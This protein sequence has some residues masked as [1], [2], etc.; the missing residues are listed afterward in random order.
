MKIGIYFH[1]NDEYPSGVEHY[2]L[3]MIR[4]LSLHVPEN[5]Y[6]VFTSRPGMIEKYVGKCDHVLVRRSND[7]NTRIARIL[8]EHTRLPTLAYREGLDVLHCPAYICP[9]RGG[10]TPYVVTVHD[11]IALDHPEWCKPS[12]AAYFGL[13]MKRAARQASAVVATS[14]RTKSDLERHLGADGPPVRVIYP[15]IDPIFH[16]RMSQTDLHN[17]RARYGLPE[18][19]CLY[20]GNLEPKKNIDVLLR[21]YEIAREK[22]AAC[23][24]V[25]VGKR[26][27]RLG[28]AARRI[29]E[30]TSAGEI[31]TP[32][33]VRRED[34]PGIYQMADMYI[35]TSFY[36]GFGFPPLEAMASGIPVLSSHCGALEETVGN[37]AY[38]IDPNDPEMIADGILKMLT[39]RSLQSKHIQLGL[40]RAG[41]FNWQRTVRELQS[42]YAELAA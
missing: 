14:R 34:L 33:Y 8:W 38:V 19:Y 22:G 24:L 23:R 29:E 10:K 2:A 17:I 41:R 31:V 35:C 4:A 40:S 13:V 6:V 30:L 37:A 5:Q 39:V 28:P 16:E 15:G 26:R 11:T 9:A 25:L 1:S 20:V 3:H 27:W 36:E 42:L 12:N 7:T 21:A 18:T 32:G